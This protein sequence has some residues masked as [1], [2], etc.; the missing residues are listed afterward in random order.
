MPGP[1]QLRSPLQAG[2]QGGNGAGWCHHIGQSIRCQQ[3]RCLSGTCLLASS[4]LSPD[5]QTGTLQGHSLCGP[6]QSSQAE[7]ISAPIPA[8][9]PA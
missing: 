8:A 7:G 6:L 3:L 5:C 2:A 4:P 1:Q 9:Q